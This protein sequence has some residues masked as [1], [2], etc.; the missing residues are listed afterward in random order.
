MKVTLNWFLNS[1]I[2]PSGMDTNFYESNGSPDSEIYL[3]KK[4]DEK[5]KQMKEDLLSREIYFI[6]Y[7]KDC[8]E[9]WL[10]PKDWGKKK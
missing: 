1:S 7:K 4:W 10:R 5:F 3:C 6:N 9:V 8:V 2:I